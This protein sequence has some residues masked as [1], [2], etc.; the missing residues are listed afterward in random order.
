MCS[1]CDPGSLRVG[2]A[3]LSLLCPP[4]DPQEAVPAQLQLQ[5][6]LWGF[7]CKLYPVGLF[8]AVPRLSGK[9]CKSTVG[10]VSSLRLHAV[11][12]FMTQGCIPW[13]LSCGTHLPPPGS[14][15]RVLLAAWGRVLTV[16][17]QICSGHCCCSGLHN[18]GTVSLP[19]H[20]PLVHSRAEGWPAPSLASA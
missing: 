8:L 6:G 4:R 7:D 20:S 3:A 10:L 11:D 12:L 13:L 16:L 18:T 19:W 9:C 17:T 5:G 1:A 15:L 14:N 2:G